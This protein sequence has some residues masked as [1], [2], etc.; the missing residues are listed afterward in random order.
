MTA[1]LPPSPQ[2][3]TGAPCLSFDILRDSLGDS[4]TYYPMTAY[5]TSGTQGGKEN[6]NILIKM[7]ELRRT[8]QEEEEEDS[9]SVC[10]CVHLCLFVCLSVYSLF[11]YVYVCTCTCVCMCV[12][13]CTCMCAHLTVTGLSGDN[14]TLEDDEPQMETVMIQHPRAVNRIRVRFDRSI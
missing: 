9:M 6:Y 12:N 3:Q 10:L 5:L 13:T 1:Y 14:E 7:A 4:R 2:A 11:V 8:T